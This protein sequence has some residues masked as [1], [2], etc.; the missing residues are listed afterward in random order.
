MRSWTERIPRSTFRQAY[1][2]LGRLK[3]IRVTKRNGYGA[4]NGRVVRVALRG[5]EATVRLSGS[6]MRSLLG[7]RSD[8]F[9][10]VR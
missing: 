9:R 8:W 6:E 4:W 5:T 3:S 1:P 10:I 7:L 2:A